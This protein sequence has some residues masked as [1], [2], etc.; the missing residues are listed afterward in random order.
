V[1][2]QARGTEDKPQKWS[3]PGGTLLALR[4]SEWLGRTRVVY[5]D[6][7]R[8]CLRTLQPECRNKC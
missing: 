3:G 8:K 2:Q 1:C 6:D 5:R 4:L 7:A